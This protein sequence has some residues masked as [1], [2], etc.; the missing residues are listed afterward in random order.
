MHGILGSDAI[1]TLLVVAE[2]ASITRA[3]ERL[4]LT[5]QAV[6]AQ[7]KRLESSVGRQLVE[8]H[9]KGV[10]VTRDGEAMLAYAEQMAEID[11]RV[12]NHFSHLSISGSIRIGLVEGFASTGLPSVLAALR[13][14]QPDLD[15]SV[16]A[17]ATDRLLSRFD[18]RKLD[19]VIGLQRQGQSRGETLLIDRVCWFGDAEAFADPSRPLRLLLHPEPSFARA[20]VIEAMTRSGRAYAIQYESNSREGLRAAAIAGLGMAALFRP[21]EHED[22]PPVPAGLPDLGT[23]E[24]FM[25]ADRTDDEAARLFADLLRDCATSVLRDRPDHH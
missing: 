4:F 1:Q 11:R 5:Q 19:V 12:R 23:A 3:G 6:S 17:A 21:F 24:L 13:A 2:E 16:E 25:R 8:R 14:S 18:N 9:G 10:R 15:I 7:I 22:L 20:V